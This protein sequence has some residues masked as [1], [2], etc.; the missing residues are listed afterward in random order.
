MYLGTIGKY[1]PTQFIYLSNYIIG[2]KLNK[3]KRLFHL[4]PDGD[5]IFRLESI[6]RYIESAH[7][8]FLKKIPLVPGRIR[9]HDLWIGRPPPLPLDFL[10]TNNNYQ[11]KSMYLP[12]CLL[13]NTL[14]NRSCSN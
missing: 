8:F 10:I 4:H 7:K 2:F 6:S 5:I 14:I 3:K 13:H 1:I 12:T 9:N 11:P